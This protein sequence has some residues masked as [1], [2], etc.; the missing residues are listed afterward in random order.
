MSNIVLLSAK[1]GNQTFTFS[2]HG[3]NDNKNKKKPISDKNNPPSLIAFKR[4][5]IYL[6][7]CRHVWARTHS[8]IYFSRYLFQSPLVKISCSDLKPQRLN[9]DR[10]PNFYFLTLIDAQIKNMA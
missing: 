8:N 2:T 3:E 1:K 6:K 10:E 4:E 5:N 7:Q 9:R